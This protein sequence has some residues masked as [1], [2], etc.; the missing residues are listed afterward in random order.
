MILSATT[1]TFEILKLGNYKSHINETF[2]IYVPPYHLS[3]TANWGCQSSRGCL[4]KS[5]KESHEVIEILTLPSFKNS[6][7]NSI[8]VGIFTVIHNHLTKKKAR[9]KVGLA[10]LYS[11]T[12]E[13]IYVWGDLCLK[14]YCYLINFAI[15]KI[16]L[17]I[18]VAGLGALLFYYYLSL[19]F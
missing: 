15:E 2:A 3:F 12:G 5:T 6:L 19:Y 16:A 8:K 9:K 10:G 11:H 7:Q 4:Q 13:E 17:F 1:K 14:F 18:N